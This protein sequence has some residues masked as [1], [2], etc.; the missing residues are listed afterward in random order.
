MKSHLC[1][2]GWGPSH[3][4]WEWIQSQFERSTL[5]NH[6]TIDDWV[7]GSRDKD[8]S[9]KRIVLLGIEH[10]TDTR[11]VAW[12]EQQQQQQQQRSEGSS[13]RT[14]IPSSEIGVILGN[15]WHGHR[16]THP[17]PDL[18]PTFYWYQWF[19]RIFP[20]LSEF[21]ESDSW[22]STAASKRKRAIQKQSGA[23]QSHATPARIQWLMDRSQWQSSRLGNEHHDHPLAWVIT[24]HRDQSE[25]WQDTCQ[26]VGMRVVASRW[27]RDPPSLQPQLIVVDCVSRSDNSKPSIESATR[28]A[29]EQHPDAFL[30]VVSSFPS[31]SEWSEW[32]Q[33]GID[34]VLPRPAALQGFL[35]YWEQW[36]S[37]TVA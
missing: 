5:L 37:R 29:R 23:S 18:S 9:V 10:R 1:V 26:S 6:Q 34:A 12:L 27:D 4:P 16:R 3:G 31:W 7:I 21:I 15:D 32:Q 22:D 14:S 17:L 28:A 13:R 20:W 25:L 2:G 35:F 33:Q 30:A 8:P 19:D 24:D 36:R 11:P